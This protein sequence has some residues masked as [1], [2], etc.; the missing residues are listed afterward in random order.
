MSNEVSLVPLIRKEGEKIPQQIKQAAK[1]DRGYFGTDGVRGRANAHPITAEMALRLGQAAGKIF[2][3]EGGARRRVVIGK[4]PR[5]SSYM[6]ESAVGAG[7]MTMGFDVYSL[8]PLPTPAV[9][10]LVKSLRADLGVMIS[11]SHNPFHDNGL[12]LF[13]ADGF[14]LSDAQEAAIS[15]LMDEGVS[16]TDFVGPRAMGRHTHLDD[17]HARYIEFVKN[18][19]PR[20]LRL[21]GLRIVVDCANGAAYKVAPMAL[22]ELG[23]EVIALGVSPDGFNINEGVGSTAPQACAA[24]VVET[25][26][27]LG[28]A[29][30]GDADRV[31]L[32]DET[33]AIIDGDQIMGLIAESWAARGALKGGALVATVMSNMGLEKHLKARGLGLVRAKVGDRFV[34]AEMRERGCNLGGE[35]SGH[36]VFGD[37][38]STGDGLVAALQVMAEMVRRGEK[39]SRIGR[40]FTPYPQLLKNARYAPGADPLEKP[41]VK[42]AIAEAESRL[43]GH[44]RL[45]IRKSGT[46]P[47][48]RVMAED[49]D[50]ALVRELVEDLAALIGRAA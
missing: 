7:F 25:R 30:D 50:A 12:K 17:S 11:A 36:I 16:E 33:G 9:S 32:I 44:G 22:A 5:R 18:T 38:A 8:G 34:V 46:E 20:E 28:I 19:F 27:D 3:G 39:A 21:D 2:G 6:L 14:K 13:G 10:M 45:L 49:E 37:F 35:Q 31:H 26:A 48:I 43:E 41:E 1:A 23:A 4:D 40:V 29:L 47:L 42:N 15:A 24:K